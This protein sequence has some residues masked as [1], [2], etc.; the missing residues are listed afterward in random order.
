MTPVEM[1]DEPQFWF[2]LKH[3]TVE[4]AEDRCSSD[5]RLGPFKTRQEAAGALELAKR[6]TEEWDAADEKWEKGER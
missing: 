5:Q 4:S 1:W 3:R 6:R 2:C